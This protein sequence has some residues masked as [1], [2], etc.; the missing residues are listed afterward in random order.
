VLFASDALPK[1]GR[2]H[3]VLVALNLERRRDTSVRALR[4]LAAQRC[5]RLVLASHSDALANG[6]LPASDI[7]VSRTLISLAH[8]LRSTGER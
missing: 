3:E 8:V 2:W 5:D 1:P 6:D 7:G 4:R